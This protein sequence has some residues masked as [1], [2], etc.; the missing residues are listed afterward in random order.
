MRH[1]A[2]R[3]ASL[4]LLDRLRHRGGG[5][6]ATPP[7]HQTWMVLNCVDAVEQKVR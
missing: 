4:F 1:L 3:F 6:M 2:W 5:G 7:T